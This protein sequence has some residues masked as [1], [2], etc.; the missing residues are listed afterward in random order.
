MTYIMNLNN[1]V[2]DLKKEQ[3]VAMEKKYKT[4]KY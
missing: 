1:N 2:Y 4:F 3:L